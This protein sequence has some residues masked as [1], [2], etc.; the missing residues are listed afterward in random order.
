VSTGGQ[1]RAV[2]DCVV[3]FQATVRPT[4]PSARLFIDFIERG[5]LALCVSN[6]IMD[7]VCDMLGRPRMRAG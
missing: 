1:P 3:F 6:A 4:G 2:F 7:E 5:R